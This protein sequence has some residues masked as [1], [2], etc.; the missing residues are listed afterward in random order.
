M[1]ADLII[2]NTSAKPSAVPPKE[3]ARVYPQNF[4]SPLGIPLVLSGTF[5]ELRNNHFHAG[6]DCKTN[7][8]TG[9]NLYAIEDGYVSRFKVSRGGYGLALYVDHPNG[10]TS[11]YAHLLEFKGAIGEY[12]KNRQ[13]AVQSFELDEAVPPGMLNVKKSDIVAISGNSGSSGAPHLHF[14]IRD[15]QTEEALNPLLFGFKVPDAQKPLV[16]QAA[17]YPFSDYEKHALPK[18]Y[19]VKSVAKGVYT[20]TKDIITIN[21]PLVGLGTKTY[22]KL[23]GAS[24]L[25]GIY[26]L[27]ILDNGNPVYGFK[28]ERIPFHE[29][30]YL[31]CHIDYRRKKEGKGWMQKCFGE[32][33]NKLSIYEKTNATNGVI[34][35][36]DGLLHKISVIIK[37]VAGNSTLLS[38]MLQYQPEPPYKWN[39]ETDFNS[40]FYYDGSNSFENEEIRLNFPKGSFYTDI[41]FKYAMTASTRSDVFSM[42]HQV[43]DGKTPVH[44]YFNVAI[45]P[46][47]LPFELYEQ[48]VV[49][50][51]SISGR[52]SALNS[53][54]DGNF[55][56]ARSREFGKYYIIVDKTPP[57]I[58]PYNI[59]DGKNMSK[60]SSIIVSISDNLSG[61]DKYNAYV[62]GQW[63]LMEYDG[64]A[65]R[66]KHRF[67]GR[68][69]SGAHQFS[70]TVTDDAGN[71]K[72]YNAKFTR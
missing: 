46:K 6:I 54:W 57:A 16:Q 28:M 10:F 43:H 31:N 34:D 44:T 26:S 8:K 23:D 50:Y 63:I 51:K 45:K 39:P 68:I 3:E 47:N 65:G 58:K 22:D 20:L 33:G 67:D 2:G 66:L 70:L 36:S 4:R 49:V 53:K 30:R 12:V 25:N 1:G 17:I 60:N 32:P 71:A 24:N 64:K 48:A 52:V 9:Y 15:T 72:T 11:V 40:Y 27:E 38:Y 41:P 13:Y 5:G 62:D 69:K 56:T 21:T 18:I 14:E 59:Y 42:Y 61:I 35:L 7:K 29:T 55:L 19:E 37:D